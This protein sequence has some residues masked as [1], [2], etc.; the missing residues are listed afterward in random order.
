MADKIRVEIDLG[1]DGEIRF[2][3][4]TD[5]AEDFGDRG[6]KSLDKFSTAFQT[7]TGFVGGAAI[8]GAFKS[9]TSAAA[10]LFQSLVVDGVKAAQEQE[11]AIQ[12][13]NSALLI[14]GRYSAS[15]SQAIQDYA[16]A[17]QNTTKYA[18]E[19]IV[20]ASALIQT[21]GN[22]NEEGLKKATKGALDL[23][24]ALGKDLNSAALIVGKVA[25]G[26]LGGLSRLG[27]NLK[28]TGDRA[29]D[30]ARGLEAINQKF[31]GAAQGQ[32]N[33]YSGAIARAT[34]AYG[35][36]LEQVGNAIIK[37][38]SLINV[39]NAA[40]DGFIS[41]SKYLEANKSSFQS[42]VSNGLI[43]FVNGMSFAV[44]AVEAAVIGFMKLEAASYP[45]R[46]AFASTFNLITGGFSAASKSVEESAAK[47][48]LMNS[49]IKKLEDGQSVFG[50]IQE[51]L[52]QLKA[53]A[54]AGIGGVAEQAER[55]S[56]SMYT[57]QEDA[58]A[59]ADHLIAENQRLSA[60]GIFR[61]EEEIQSNQAKLAKILAA[62]TLSAKDRTKIQAAYSAQSR[63]IEKQRGQ[64]VTDSLGALATLQTAKT[65]EIAAVGKAAAIAQATIDTYRGASAAAAAMAGIPFVG[66]GLAIAAAAAFIAAGVF[67][68]AQIAGVPLAGGITE[69]PAGFPND[70]FPARLQTGERVVDAG[71]N[72]DLKSF[73]SDGGGIN[74][75]LQAILAR[76]NALE[77]HT[78]VNVGNRTIVDSV[79]EGIRSGRSIDV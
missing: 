56:S 27:I 69:V 42:L 54:E 75:T 14:T 10:G 39:I 8:V 76:L 62:E 58:T 7:M 32:L 37:N 12:Q 18:D 22:L 57:A 11:D 34:N 9:V 51:G 61:H 48:E 29:V 15:T 74:R 44:S 68:V 5:A 63:E 78:V 36:N 67:R 30:A 77:M 25:S 2:R 16:S 17:L 49:A 66:P 6:Q 70:S 50:G 59:T 47:L 46:A 24:A 45:L 23:S 60:D 64:A 65:K 21:L 20:S 4:L 31:G 3:K 40:T 1:Q 52:N 71:T 35:E 43:Y 72:G 19:N 38:R 28:E 73:L 79:R 33:T 41:F 26:E 55:V 13:L 53:A